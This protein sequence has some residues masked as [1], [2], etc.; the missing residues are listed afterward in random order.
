MP[1]GVAVAL[2]VAVGVALGLPVAVGVALGVAVGLIVPLG[3]ALGVAVGV[4]VV[5]GVAVGL[6]VPLGVAV[7][8]AVG[9]A[10]ADGLPV[11]VGVGVGVPPPIVPLSRNTWSGPPATG[12]HVVFKVHVWQKP[13][14]PP[15]FCQAAPWFD[16]TVR[17]VQTHTPSGRNVILAWISTQYVPSV[18]IAMLGKVTEKV[19]PTTEND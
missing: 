7:A 12:M 13:K 1:L 14:R 3:V 9:V 4:A 8:E 18:R 5:L 17:S 10:V 11:A 2:G 15:G 16:C 19:V 6:C